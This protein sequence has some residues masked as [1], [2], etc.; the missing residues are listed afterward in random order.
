MSPGQ[1]LAAL[2][3]S[4]LVEMKNVLDRAKPD[5]VLVH[6]DTTTTLAA[7]LSSFYAGIPVGH[8]E[9]GLR[10]G[11]KRAPFPEEINRKIAGCIADIHF[12]P[13]AQ[14]RDRLLGEGIQE[15]SIHVTGNT[16]IDALRMILQK[17]DQ[18][19][20]ESDIISGLV[21]TCPRLG[22]VLTVS[23]T[24]AVSRL[25]L[26]TGHRRE[27]FGRGFE[28]MCRALKD[29]ARTRRDVDIVYPVHLNPHVQEPVRR[30]LSDLPNVHLLEPVD[31][32]HF[33]YLMRRAYFIIT[34]SGGVQEE[35]STLGKP[36]LVMREAT[37]RTEALSGGT[38]KLVG[39]Q[40]DDIIE[41]SIGL[42][43]NTSLYKKMSQTDSPYGD[44]RAAERIVNILSM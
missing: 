3:A 28:N 43:D 38:A 37:E 1:E 11:N 24:R 18:P 19:H 5:M 30:I 36:V 4:I 29:I 44:G 14:A 6:G 27:S 7:S 12:A 25:I 9:A 26:V 39:M 41:A 22:R 40:R 10:T 13:T 17:L 34:D 33:A 35:A 42:L 2:T 23:A 31:Y 16:V 21:R 8:V 32:L 20:A 15:S